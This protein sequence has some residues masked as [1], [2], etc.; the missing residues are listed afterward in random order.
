MSSFNPLILMKTGYRDR[1]LLQQTLRQRWP[2]MYTLFWEWIM[3]RTHCV[4]GILIFKRPGILSLT[5]LKDETFQVGSSL[6][7]YATGISSRKISTIA[8]LRWCMML[9]TLIIATDLINFMPT[10]MRQETEF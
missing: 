8:A 3:I 10:K 2:T 5:L 4:V 6:T 9:L 1:T 7:D